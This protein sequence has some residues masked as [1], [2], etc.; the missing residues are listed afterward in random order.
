MGDLVNAA[1]QFNLGGSRV[2]SQPGNNLFAGFGAGTSNTSGQGNAFFGVVAGQANTVGSGNAFFGS[3]AGRANTTGLRNAFFGTLAGKA[4]T[5]GSDNAFF[6]TN[7]GQANNNGVDNV[8]FGEAGFN[9]TTGSKNAFFG[10]LSG[11]SNTIG[12]S[13]TFAGFQTGLRNTTGSFNTFVGSNGDF[14]NTTPAGNYN[15]LLGYGTSVSSGVSNSTAVGA[16]AWAALN[17]TLILGSIAGL[18]G[19]TNSVNVG[20]GTINPAYRLDVVGGVRSQD[21][22]ST[23]FV[24]ETT[25]GTNSWARIFM[26]TPN[27]G[28]FI[29]TSRGFNGDQFYIWDETS[30]QIRMAIATNG[31]VDFSANVRV[32]GIVTQ[33]SDA[34]L[35]Q[36]ISK[37]GYGLSEVLRLRPVSWRWKENP[38][39]G[40]Q[41]GL[42][43]Q[44]VEQ[45]LPELVS[46]SEDA[47]QTKGLNYIGLVPILINAVKEQQKQIAQQRARIEEQGRLINRQQGQLAR[48]KVLVC[49]RSRRAAPCR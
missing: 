28:W 12:E 24:A 6:G 8:F 32:A 31:D 45:V 34:R 7:A 42:V 40:Q 2:L 26:R 22:A 4:N 47:D 21:S 39:T 23:H 38:E 46:T 36:D 13:N 25:G 14:N 15:T 44:E 33:G 19:A 11:Y 5:S 49:R 16:K 43:A 20:I 9:N 17:N 10:N 30:N 37:L 18:N 41:L 35:K 1:T 27:R 3:E 29:G 48:F